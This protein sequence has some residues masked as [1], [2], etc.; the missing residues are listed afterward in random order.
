MVVIHHVP[1]VVDA[2]ERMVPDRR[3]DRRRHGHKDAS[4]QAISHRQRENASRLGAGLRAGHVF[5]DIT[6]AASRDAAKNQMPDTSGLRD[7]R[8]RED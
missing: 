4:E 3:V 7:F 6:A 5:E 8:Y 2:D 1:V